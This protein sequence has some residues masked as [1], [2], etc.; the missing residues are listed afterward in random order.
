MQVAEHGEAVAVHFLHMCTQYDSLN[1]YFFYQL[2]LEFWARY[3]AALGATLTIPYPNH[4]DW[5]YLDVIVGG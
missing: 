3:G 5:N 2:E 1:K 4:A